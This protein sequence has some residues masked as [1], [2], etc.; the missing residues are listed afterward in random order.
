MEKSGCL[1]ANF[2]P[3]HYQGNSLA[4]SILFVALDLIS[5]KGPREPWNEVGSQSLAKLM[6]RVRT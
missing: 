2:G 6:I 4:Y 3:P 1:K 5:T